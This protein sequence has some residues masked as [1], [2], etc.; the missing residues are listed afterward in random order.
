MPKEKSVPVADRPGFFGRLP[1]RSLTLLLVLGVV[2]AISMY[3]A[4][5][6]IRSV[7]AEVGERKIQIDLKEDNGV[8]FGIAVEGDK[9]TRTALA[10]LTAD[11]AASMGLPLVTEKQLR[12]AEMSTD[13]TTG[14][15]QFALSPGQS[16]AFDPSTFTWRARSI[17]Q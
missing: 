11:K 6:P 7:T 10:V 1:R 5:R 17:Q 2:F 8:V 4:S 15:C 9:K 14:A 13:K 16:I 3:Q 12:D